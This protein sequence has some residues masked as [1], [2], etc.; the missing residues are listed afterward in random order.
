[1]RGGEDYSVL[2][3]ELLAGGEDTTDVLLLQNSGG[4]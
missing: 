4:I 2:L 1:M 3:L